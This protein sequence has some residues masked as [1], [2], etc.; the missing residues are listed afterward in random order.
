MPMSH[1][2][3]S[4]EPMSLSLK[5]R[6]HRLIF[7]G[8]KAESVVELADSDSTTDSV[9]VGR[10]SVLNMFNILNPLKS[11]D[12]LLESADSKLA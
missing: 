10:L 4:F 7:T 5:A 8:S 12:S 9:I 11:A 1:V 6:T 3:V 2:T